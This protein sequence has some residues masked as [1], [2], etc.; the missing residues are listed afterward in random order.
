MFSILERC[1]EMERKH[2]PYRQGAKNKV[3][4]KWMTNKEFIAAGYIAKMRHGI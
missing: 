2:I 4:F 3:K 1:Y